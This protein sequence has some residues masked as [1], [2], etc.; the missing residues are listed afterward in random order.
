M[1]AIA[2]IDYYEP[3]TTGDYDTSEEVGDGT[4]FKDAVPF[5]SWIGPLDL[6]SL[7]GDDDLAR[8][9]QR[10]WFSEYVKLGWQIKEEFNDRGLVKGNYKALFDYYEDLIKAIA[11]VDDDD[12]HEYDRYHRGH[13]DDDDEE[14]Y[15]VSDREVEKFT[16]NFLNRITIPLVEIAR[17]M[18]TLSS[19]GLKEHAGFIKESALGWIF[20][21]P[22]PETDRWTGIGPRIGVLK[23]AVLEE[24]DRH[25]IES[26]DIGERVA[27]RVGELTRAPSKEL[28]DAI[29]NECTTA[30]DPATIVSLYH[31]A[32]MSAHVTRPESW[33]GKCWITLTQKYVRELLKDALLVITENISKGTTTHYENLKPTYLDALEM[34]P[35][36]FIL[37]RIQGP[38]IQNL[39][40]MKAEPY[41]RERLIRQTIKW[42]VLN[43]KGH[44]APR[45]AIAT[46]LH[47]GKTHPSWFTRD[48]FDVLDACFKDA[49]LDAKVEIVPFL[50]VLQEKGMIDEIVPVLI[51]NERYDDALHSLERGDFSRSCRTFLHDILIHR[52]TIDEETSNRLVARLKKEISSEVEFQ[53]ARRDDNTIA[54]FI[55]C[56]HLLSNNPPRPDGE[57]AWKRWFGQFW[58]KHKSLRNLKRALESKGL[59]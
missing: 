5:S 58:S 15:E 20:Q 9:L 26:L 7:I 42:L 22:D 16:E 33:M 19:A 18:N 14:E 12:D 41:Q 4:S 56:I 1:G 47:F 52:P 49:R 44:D 54:D 35:V 45:D 24:L 8:K 55:D 51:V 40:S 37:A 36:D 28:A 11:I 38:L 6:L 27:F 23:A 29:V 48:D 34:M 46:Y 57:V 50:E 25:R 3:P 2:R 31:K 30:D 17:F 39:E 21:V 59:I 10:S 13:G 32:F 53:A 43:Y